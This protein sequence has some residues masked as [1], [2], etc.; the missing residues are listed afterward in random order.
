MSAPKKRGERVDVATLLFR[1]P[2][3]DDAEALA[4]LYNNPAVYP[5]LL[6]LPYTDAAHWRQRLAQP[7]EGAAARSL[8]LVVL[9]GDALIATGGIYPAAPFARRF[10]AFALGMAVG[11]DW[12]GRGV[13][14]ALLHRL[15]EHADRW[16]GALRIELGVYADNAA[17]VALYRKHGFELEGTQRAY[18]L[19]GG[20]Y[21]DSLMMARLAPSLRAAS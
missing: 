16:L 6:Q 10:H 4:A 3:A 12:Q 1:R 20:Q 14:A 9:Q 19:R 8:F 13:G 15:L 17:P 21:V 5:G 2:V 11:A 7:S 18:A